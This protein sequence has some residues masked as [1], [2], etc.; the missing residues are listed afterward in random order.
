MKKIQ[1]STINHHVYNPDCD[2]VTGYIDEDTFI[3]Y[4]IYTK[5]TKHF[6]RIG[7]RME[8]TGRL[9]EVGQEFMEVYTGEN[10]V[11]SSKKRSHSRHYY[12]DSIPASYMEA[13]ETLKEYYKSIKQIK[14]GRDI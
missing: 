13:W 5:P 1:Q 4:G 10:Y 6:E 9:I 14:N 7:S 11:P 8:H 2:L 12:S 3:T